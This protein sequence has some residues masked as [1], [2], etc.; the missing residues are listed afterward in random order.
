MS[1]LSLADVA[2]DQATAKRFAWPSALFGLIKT[3]ANWIERRRQLQALTELDDH[4][5]NDVGLSREQARREAARPF[6]NHENFYG[7]AEK[8]CTA[9]RFDTK[10]RTLEDK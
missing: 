1:Q 2:T 9:S 10:I 5:L 8:G 6:W 4:L 3:I 7:M